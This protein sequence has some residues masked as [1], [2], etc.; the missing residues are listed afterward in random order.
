[1]PILE[2]VGLHL[3]AAIKRKK[4]FNFKKKEEINLLVIVVVCRIH[5]CWL[6]SICNH[7]GFF[8]LEIHKNVEKSKENQEQVR[9]LHSIS[10]NNE[11]FYHL[12]CLKFLPQR[13]MFGC[14]NLEKRHQASRAGKTNLLLKNKH[15][16]FTARE[17]TIWGLILVENLWYDFLPGLKAAWSR[18]RIDVLIASGQ[19][20]VFTDA[21][22]RLQG[23]WLHLWFSQDKR[24]VE[25]RED[26]PT[27]KARWPRL[28]PTEH[29]YLHRQNA[30][31]AE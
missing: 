3:L 10:I 16:H 20:W 31:A 6:F 9:S 5:P 1:M 18:N 17:R 2:R 24:G 27:G 4:F 7:W 15:H 21:S 22:G 29:F 19:R 11:I 8:W 30:A 14:G 28:R 13:G 25:Q 26:H 12:F 23:A